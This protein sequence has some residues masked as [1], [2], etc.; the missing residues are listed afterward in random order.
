MLRKQLMIAAV[1]VVAACGTLS[2]KTVRVP[3]DSASIQTGIRGA[4]AGDNAGGHLGTREPLLDL[5]RIVA[6]GH[7]QSAVDV[8]R[9]V[10]RVDLDVLVGDAREV[11][12]TEGAGVTARMAAK[13]EDGTDARAIESPRQGVKIRAWSR[14]RCPMHVACLSL[15]VRVPRHLVLVALSHSFCE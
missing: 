4:E 14:I 13:E 8:I 2:A 12:V 7:Q 1:C 15:E 5:L 11:D 3:D 9:A 6:D 10:G